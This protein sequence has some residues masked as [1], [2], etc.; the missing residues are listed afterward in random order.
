MLNNLVQCKYSF[1]VKKT[2]SVICN[3]SVKCKYSFNVEKNSSISNNSVKHKHAVQMY[4]GLIVKN[5]F[6]LSYSV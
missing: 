3:N 2:V 4:Y 5:I 1:N 6:I